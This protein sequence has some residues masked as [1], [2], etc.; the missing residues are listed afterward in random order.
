MSGRTGVTQT[1]YNQCVL[2]E[3]Y[4]NLANP[5]YSRADRGQNFVKDYVS[6]REQNDKAVA[7]E[8]GSGRGLVYSIERGRTN[9]A[10][11]MRRQ[12][13]M[14]AQLM[15]TYIYASGFPGMHGGNDPTANATKTYV[16][17]ANE[18]QVSNY[19]YTIIDSGLVSLSHAD[20]FQID[21]DSDTDQDGNSDIKVWYTLGDMADDNGTVLGGANVY[22]ATPRD[23]I[24]N[25]YI[26]NNANVTYT[27]YGR[28]TVAAQT[29]VE[30]Q[31][32]VNTLI[33][34]YEAGLTNPTV[35]YY[36]KPGSDAQII[37]SV[38]VPYDGNVTGT[39][40]IDSSIMRNET[41]TDYLYKFVNP[42]RADATDNTRAN[43]TKAYFK[44][45]DSNFVRGDK[46]ARVQF[47]LG[48]EGEPGTTYTG[49]NYVTGTIRS[50][51]LNDNSIVNVV[52]IELDIY[53]LS[54]AG[55]FISPKIGRTVW[56]ATD[57]VNPYIQVGQM[58]GIYL[59][60]EYLN[61]RG[62]ADIYIQADTSYLVFDGSSGSPKQRPLG[63]AYN[64]LSEI[65]QDLLKLD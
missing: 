32:F 38:A 2:G 62:S 34:A 12:P 45:L 58:Y 40:P 55:E 23:G 37:N 17:P 50:I 43:G 5:T 42:N 49:S 63:T 13:V 64:L 39:N 61:E 10:D 57:V 54:A 28:R 35:N 59:P 6:Y 46:Y 7:Y 22:S 25:Y 15:N 8:P 18:G 3:N 48:V 26:Y 14:A 20:Y 1:P 21:L 33:A 56:N 65:K 29:N 4:A 31:L 19:P 53:D 47:Y 16:D 9:F 51:Q 30:K 41:N 52:P 60:M 44:V 36:D 11:A 27:G 24:N